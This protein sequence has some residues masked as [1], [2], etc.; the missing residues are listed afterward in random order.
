MEIK[1][2]NK[3]IVEEKILEK[4][5]ELLSSMIK[6]LQGKLHIFITGMVKATTP[7]QHNY[8]LDKAINY[9]HDP[10]RTWN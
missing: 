9:T 8:Y 10:T 4:E 3:K 1:F 5:N 6:G 7:E 2:L